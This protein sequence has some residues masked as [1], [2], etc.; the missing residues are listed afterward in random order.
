MASK[1]VLICDIDGVVVDSMVRHR[2]HLHEETITNCDWPGVIEG[3][4]AY[5]QD[6]DG[7]VLIPE[8]ISLLRWAVDQF[9][10]DEVIFVT[11]RMEHGRGPTHLQLQDVWPGVTP[12]QLYMMPDI[13]MSASGEWLVDKNLCGPWVLDAYGAVPH[14]QRVIEHLRSD[15][16]DWDLVL[17]I[18]DHAIVCDMYAS[19]GIRVLR[20]MWADPKLWNSFVDKHRGG[21]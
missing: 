5:N 7:D 11:A 14:K 2:R 15:H 10:V 18:D 13:L 17:A 3:F 8:G 19:F 16:P 21:K 9:H 12:D 6:T 1:R 4:Y 20:P